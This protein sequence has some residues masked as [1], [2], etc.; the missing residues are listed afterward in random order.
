MMMM[1]MRRFLIITMTM[2]VTMT[3]VMRIVKRRI[4]ALMKVMMTMVMMMQDEQRHLYEF[5]GEINS[6][7]VL[8]VWKSLPFL[9]CSHL[10]INKASIDG[11]LGAPL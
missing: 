6:Q 2:T 11:K 4:M 3:L 10:R 1:K 8:T 7:L 5:S 9:L